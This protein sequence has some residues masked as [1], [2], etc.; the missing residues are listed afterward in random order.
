MLQMQYPKCVFFCEF[1]VHMVSV[2][3]FFRNGI[4]Q[5]SE[6]QVLEMLLWKGLLVSLL[7]LV[8]QGYIM[9]LGSLAGRCVS[10]GSSNW[11]LRATVVGKCCCCFCFCCV[12]LL[13]LFAC[14]RSFSA[15]PPGR[16]VFHGHS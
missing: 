1:W 9:Y 13:F 12:L 8:S 6:G 16:A 7:A 5:G 15:D 3:F 2:L 4:S 11:P 10:H 14:G